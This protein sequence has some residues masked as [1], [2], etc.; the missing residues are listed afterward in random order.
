MKVDFENVDLLNTHKIN[1]FKAEISRTDV[2]LMVMVTAM[3]LLLLIN[4]LLRQNCSAGKVNFAENFILFHFHSML[5]FDKL[6][7]IS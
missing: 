1:D 6:G 5:F 7:K 4:S 3:K 2:M